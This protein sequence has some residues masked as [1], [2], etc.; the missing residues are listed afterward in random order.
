MNKSKIYDSELLKRQMLP[1]ILMTSLVIALVATLGIT[2]GF[3][4]F[5]AFA[6]TLDM[7]NGDRYDGADGIKQ[8]GQAGGICTQVSPGHM[9]CTPIRKYNGHRGIEDEGTMTSYEV[10]YP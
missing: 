7:K 9:V 6:L 4:H 10:E 2:M 8:Q 5:S 3:N 1:E